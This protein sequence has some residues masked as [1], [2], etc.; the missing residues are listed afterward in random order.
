MNDL[1]VVYSSIGFNIVS[2]D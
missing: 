1:L 2:N